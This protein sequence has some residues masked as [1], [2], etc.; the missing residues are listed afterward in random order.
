MTEVRSPRYFDANDTGGYQKAR[1]TM[2]Y[3]SRNL[4]ESRTEAPG[5]PEA[6]TVA[7]TYTLDRRQ[8]TR[9]DA[10]G[11][12]WRTIYHACCGRPQASIDPLGH[13]AISNN[14][15]RGNVAELRQARPERSAPDPAPAT[16]PV[17]VV[18]AHLRR[19]EGAHSIR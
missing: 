14:D 17:G 19:G 4:L 16:D 8:D 15:Y 6:G 3:T 9:T 5:T 7:I 10:R 11:N 2:L 18:H 1:T 12:D 13:G